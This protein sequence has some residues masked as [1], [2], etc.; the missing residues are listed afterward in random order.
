MGTYR[1]K[2]FSLPIPQAIHITRWEFPYC[3]GHDCRL[4][5]IFIYRR[6]GDF[7]HIG[8]LG[9][10]MNVPPVVAANSSKTLRAEG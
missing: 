6:S 4:V 5:V 9:G 3:R 2:W 10:A 1:R 8:L 7:S